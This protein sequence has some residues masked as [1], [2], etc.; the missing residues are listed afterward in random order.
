MNCEAAVGLLEL[1]LYGEL[2]GE[3][4]ELLE[5]HLASCATCREKYEKARVLHTLLDGSREEPPPG[6]LAGCRREL[7]TRLEAN[8]SRRRVGL[9]S[10]LWPAWVA[11]VAAAAALVGLG[12]LTARWTASPATTTAAV[13][14]LAAARVRFI[15]PESDGRVRIGLEER[16]QFVLRGRV[17]EEPIQ[18]WLLAAAREA[19]DPGLRLDSLELLRTRARQEP[20]R[21]AL[22][23]AVQRDPNAGVRM[24]ALDA[25]KPLATEAEVRDTLARVLLSDENPGVRIQAI[26]LLIEQRRRNELVGVLQQVIHRENNDYVRLRCRQALE[27]LNAS[28]GTF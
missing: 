2:E 3:Q 13:P 23:E 1:Y 17:D 5:Q 11:R 28:L 14:E 4:E 18:R 24:K 22:L 19:A 15:E 8:E 6:L 20:V 25:L 10:W 21:R 7:F 9:M 26:D 27:E 12:F 16:R